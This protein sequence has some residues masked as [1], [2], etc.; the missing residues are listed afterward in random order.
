[1]ATL[2]RVLIEKAAV[3]DSEVGQDRA[4][5]G[6]RILITVLKTARKF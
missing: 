4:F 6:S 5:N 3:S 2:G 1:M